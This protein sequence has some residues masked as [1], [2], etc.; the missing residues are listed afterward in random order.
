V[1]LTIEV[2]WQGFRSPRIDPSFELDNLEIVS[3]PRR[4]GTTTLLSGP[5][6]QGLS[7]S[8]RLRSKR[9]GQARVFNIRVRVDGSPFELPDARLEVRTDAPPPPPPPSR[10]GDLAAALRGRSQTGADTSTD[11]PRSTRSPSSRRPRVY[12]R[13][14]VSPRNPYRGQQTL[15]TLYIYYQADVGN[16]RP[17][18]MPQFQG[19]WVREMAADDKAVLTLEGDRKT[20]RSVLLRR[21]LYPLRTGTLEITPTV[22]EMIVDSPPRPG[23]E[24]RGQ[25]IRRSSNGLRVSVRP[26]PED[27]PDSLV[28][29]LPVGSLTAEAALES[30]EVEVGEAAVWTLT[31]RG[32]GHLRPLPD[33]TPSLPP[34]SRLLPLQAT[35][36]EEIRGTTLHQLRRWRLPVVADT[37]GPL[38]LPAVEFPYFD[39]GEGRLRIAR[40]AEQ[41]LQV[42]QRSPEVS[43]G[44][45][46]TTTPPPEDREGGGRWSALLPGLPG[47]LGLLTV[48]AVGGLGFLW[49]RRR[50]RHGS[51][52][53][54]GFRD[55][56][57]R[58]LEGALQAA[59][60]TSHRHPRQVAAGLEAAW[61]EFLEEGYLP[62]GLPRN[63]WP[64]TLARFGPRGSHRRREERRAAVATLLEELRL[65]AQAPQLA[66]IRTQVEEIHDR[67]RRVL[68]LLPPLRDR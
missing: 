6:S 56:P 24:T 25:L 52:G 5:A 3:G 27:S 40:T 34:G 42:R 67:S 23:R 39:P 60:G 26:L 4:S 15:Y 65:L 45:A 31:L 17:Q 38:T 46:P 44:E 59:A 51:P 50:R 30:S 64:L 20:F 48:V 1:E 10:L 63:E 53:S 21:V 55:S 18:E 33:P 12:L 57:R 29:V 22:A 37:P 43:G 9:V 32:T 61:R 2:R 35:G 47:L 58:R 41:T 11:S 7:L 54:S 8:W 28:P 13:A 49:Y 68:Q 36:G 66:D 19:F 16:I 62:P 14:E